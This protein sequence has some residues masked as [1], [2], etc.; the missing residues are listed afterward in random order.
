MGTIQGLYLVSA[1]RVHLNG[2]RLVELPVAFL[3][4]GIPHRIDNGV[5]IIVGTNQQNSL[6]SS[7]MFFK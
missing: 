1:E 3:T 7:R 4:K 6:E 2:I 5:L